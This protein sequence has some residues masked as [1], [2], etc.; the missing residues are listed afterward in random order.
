MCLLCTD[1]QSILQVY[2]RVVI[3]I[4]ILIYRNAFT[5]GD[6][7]NP[8]FHTFFFALPWNNGINCKVSHL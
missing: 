8:H 3:C 7:K 5:T 6:R 4:E 2:S 1:F